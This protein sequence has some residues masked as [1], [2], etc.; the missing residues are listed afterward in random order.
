M[1]QASLVG[2]C[3]AQLHAARRGV[4]NTAD[5][6][7]AACLVVNRTVVELQL[8]VG[9]VLERVGDRAVFTGQ[10]EQLVFGHREIDVHLR[11]VRNGRKRLRHRRAH[12]C[13]DT[14]RQRTY[15]AVGR[16]LHDRV[17]E[18]IGGIYALCLGLCE[19]RLCRQQRVFGC[20]EVVLRHDALCEE[21]LL[22]VICQLGRC[23]AGLCRC[24][25]GF[26][27]LER[28]L[29][30]YLVY[31]EKGLSFR[32]RLALGDTQFGDGSRNLRIDVDVLA[33]A[34]RCRVVALDFAVGSGNG[35]HAVLRGALLRG[36]LTAR[37]GCHEACHDS[38]FHKCLL[39]TFLLF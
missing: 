27:C 11:I 39:H 1:E 19:L 26:C 30:R 21:F 2:E 4:D 3:R 22:A 23:H 14:V 28:C 15:H 31:D 16:G 20:R 32:N 35:R 37:N 18:V 8:Y 17:G 25:I 10:I 38:S 34:D 9:H 33:S 5:R 36:C 6:L 29:V 12:Q 13:A 24:D 7:D